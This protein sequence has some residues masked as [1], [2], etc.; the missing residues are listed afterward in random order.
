MNTFWWSLRVAVWKKIYFNLWRKEDSQ[1]FFFSIR[2]YWNKSSRK[3]RES[4][5]IKIL[6]DRFQI[7][8]AEYIYYSADSYENASYYDTRSKLIWRW[9]GHYAAGILTLTLLC[10]AMKV[11]I[12][13]PRP[14]FLDTCKPREATNC[15][16]E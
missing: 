11:I 3:C 16:N 10:E 4:H 12:G 6:F 2:L 8:I 13:E 15:T 1:S 7:W 9:Y 5:F 14:H